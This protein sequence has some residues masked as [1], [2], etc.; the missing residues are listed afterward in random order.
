MRDQIF[1]LKCLEVKNSY[2]LLINIINFKLHLINFVYFSETIAIFSR[3]FRLTRYSMPRPMCCTRARAHRNTGGLES[4][5]T[6]DISDDTED[7][8][9]LCLQ[10]DLKAPKEGVDNFKFY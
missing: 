6:N 9:N 4:E 2:I 10:E 5:E 1:K 8:E 3:F 7:A